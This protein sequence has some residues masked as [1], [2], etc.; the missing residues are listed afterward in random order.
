M[1]SSPQDKVFRHNS[2]FIMSDIDISPEVGT[3]CYTLAT[4]N[5]YGI[6]PKEC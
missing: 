5:K 4:E 1:L 2:Q 6:H 3:K